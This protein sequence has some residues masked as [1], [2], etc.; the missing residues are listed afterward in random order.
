ML[1]INLINNATQYTNDPQW[2][3]WW[4]IIFNSKLWDILFKRRRNIR[5]EKEEKKLKQKVNNIETIIQSE[6]IIYCKRL[7]LLPFT[8]SVQFCSLLLWNIEMKILIISRGY[9]LHCLQESFNWKKKSSEWLA[10]FW[11]DFKVKWKNTIF[12]LLKTLFFVILVDKKLL[13]NWKKNIQK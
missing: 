5:M 7:K 6:L 13:E 8:N 2:R 9:N 12:H 1:P 10:E 4:E 3:L 11:L